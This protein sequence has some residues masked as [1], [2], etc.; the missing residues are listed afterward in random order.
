MIPMPQLI[1]GRK[2]EIRRLVG[3]IGKLWPIRIVY[4]DH[5]PKVVFKLYL[6]ALREKDFG[7]ALSSPQY[8]RDLFLDYLDSQTVIEV[9]HVYALV[10]G[11]A[12]ATDP[13]HDQIII[14]GCHGTTT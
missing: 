8:R 2:Q 7:D 13:T 3:A 11:L 5:A 12:V 4:G 6:P 1:E 10:H 9:G 14:E